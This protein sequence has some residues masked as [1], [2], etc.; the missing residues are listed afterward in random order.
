MFSKVLILVFC[1]LKF[2]FSSILKTLHFHVELTL[3]KRSFVGFG[4]VL[5]VQFRSSA[6]DQLNNDLVFVGAK[7]HLVRSL[8]FIQNNLL[9]AVRLS[10]TELV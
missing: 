10:A 2:S 7:G 9:I 8:N 5:L 3:L 1:L 6:S 4:L